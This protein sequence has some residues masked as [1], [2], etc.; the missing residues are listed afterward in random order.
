MTNTPINPVYL[1]IQTSDKDLIKFC[2]QL[3]PNKKPI[4][5]NCIGQ[6]QPQGLC[7]WN[8]EAYVRKYGGSVVY[9]WVF[10]VWPKSHIEAM[11]HAIYKDTNGELFD[12][13]PHLAG[14]D[15]PLQSTFLEDDSIAIDIQRIPKVPNRYYKLSNSVA[16]NNFIRTYGNLL[17]IDAKMSELMYDSGYRAEGQLAIAMHE[18]FTPTPNIIALSASKKYLDLLDSISKQKVKL[19]AAI[20]LLKSTKL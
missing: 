16:T 2:S 6:Q 7:Y 20:N 9:G 1:H 17:K 15:Q 12:V 19:G 5:I 18:N 14:Y 10:S 3:N 4:S 13:S 8:A 11:H